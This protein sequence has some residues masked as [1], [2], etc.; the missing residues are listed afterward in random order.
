MAHTRYEHIANNCAC[1][2]TSITFNATSNRLEETENENTS[3]RNEITSLRAAV[4]GKDRENVLYKEELATMSDLLAKYKDRVASA[5]GTHA[6]TEKQS[7][8]F[9]SCMRMHV[10]LSSKTNQTAV[11][12]PGLENSGLKNPA[13]E[14]SV[15]FFQMGTG[16]YRR[17]VY[18]AGV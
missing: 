8:N 6:S 17:A 5:E 13:L 1:L 18:L 4:A 2:S 14:K 10:K 3:L 16:F 9:K 7:V 12:H 11:L 15:G